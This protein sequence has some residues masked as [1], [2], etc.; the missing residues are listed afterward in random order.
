M[1][2]VDCSAGALVAQLDRALVYETKGHRFESCRAR[3]SLPFGNKD[4][5]HFPSLHNILI[6]LACCRF[7]A[8][9]L[10]KFSTFKNLKNFPGGVLMGFVFLV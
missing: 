8:A 4:L 5:A 3:H 9:L 2:H 1:I 7:V 10:S 6:R